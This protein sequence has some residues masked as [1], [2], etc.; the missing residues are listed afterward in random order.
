MLGRFAHRKANGLVLYP[1]NE[2][3]PVFKREGP[4]EAIIVDRTVL[5][6]RCAH[7][8]SGHEID[9]Y[10]HSG[11]TRR[12]YIAPPNEA[13]AFFQVDQVELTVGRRHLSWKIPPDHELPWPHIKMSAWSADEVADQFRRRL[14]SAQAAGLDLAPICQAVPSKVRK[15]IGPNWSAIVK[16]VQSL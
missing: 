8:N 2:W 10:R 3:E 1:D 7:G 4:W 16:E 13:L 5:I 14:V 6:S 12:F 9:P 15:M 11:Y